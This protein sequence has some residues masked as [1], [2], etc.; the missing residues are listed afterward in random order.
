MINIFNKTPRITA[1]TT[2]TPDPDSPLDALGL[3]TGFIRGSRFGEGTENA[4]F[5]LPRTFR[6]GVGFR[7]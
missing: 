5:P 2:I 4:H 7:F 3:P 6:M 1:N